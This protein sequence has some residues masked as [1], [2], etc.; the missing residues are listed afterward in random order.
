MAAGGAVAAL[1]VLLAGFSLTELAI[2][3]PAIGVE[4]GTGADF[5]SGSYQYRCDHGK[6]T[7][8]H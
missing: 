8:S 7:I 1:V 5:L 6:L 2:R 4:S 3:C